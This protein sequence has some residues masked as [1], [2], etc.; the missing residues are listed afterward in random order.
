MKKIF[1]FILLLS[2]FSCSKDPILYTLTT[3]VNPLEGGTLNPSIT[4]FEEGETVILNAVPS[5]EYSFFSWSGATGSNAST[6]IVMDSDKSVTA[7]FT[8]KRYSLD[9]SIEGKGTV[10]QKILKSG[11]ATDYNS[12]TLLELSA[13]PD[14]GWFFVKWKGDLSGVEN[15]VQITIDKSKNISA[16]FEQKQYPL[17]I[18]IEGEGTVDETIIKP[19]TPNDY[20]SG[21]IVQ[22]TASPVNGWSFLKWSGDL[23]S[24]KNPIEITVDMAKTIKAEFFNPT[25][26]TGLPIL[27][28]DTNGVAIDSKEDYV[29]GFASIVGGA[30]YPDLLD[31]EMKIKGRGNSTW[32]QGGIWGKKPYQIKF[33]DK[34]EILNMPKDKKWVLLAELSD[35]SLIRNKIAREI[36]N[37]SRFDYVPQAEYLEVFI[38]KE[39]VGAYLLGQKVEESKNRVNIG[40]NGYLIEIDTDANGKISDDDVYF[41]SNE[42]SSRYE[43][44]V[45]N[46]KEPSIEY[47]SDEFNLIKNHINDFETAL[48]SNNFKDPDSGYRSFIDIPSFV[49]WFIV[50]EI[51]KN[52]DARSYSSIYFN[53]IPGEKI[54]MG[55]VWDFD[56]AFG[57]VD[58]SNAENPDGFWIKENL[59]YK[60][61][62]E[63]PFFSDLIKSRFSYYDGNLSS[64]LSKIDGFEDY[65]SKSQK[66]N[67]EIWDIL[68]KDVWPIPVKYDTH[69][70]YVEYLK[71]WIDNRMS[72]LETRL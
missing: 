3:S 37:I 22:L 32:W 18:E 1:Y 17:N 33:G 36:A 38:N 13:I 26:F 69:H 49:D 4:Q 55:P 54:K 57:N 40:D 25:D 68:S 14:S 10:D 35:K 16:V 50:N 61:M 52:Q 58:Y 45:F 27:Y 8:K 24:S 65:I 19:G 7:V 46:I 11:R 71:T 9:V 47:D 34:T 44:G 43:D 30:N 5:P 70:E 29:E 41:R 72:W 53:Y 62:F 63:D 67:F 59:W 66:K 21:T 31:T 51:S 56:L 28:I 42:W 39:H 64:I 20:N 12:G 60:R 2:V 48:F 15:P 23:L 6:S